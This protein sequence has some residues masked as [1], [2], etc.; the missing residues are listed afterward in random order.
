MSR[1]HAK[2]KYWFRFSS[3][4]QPIPISTE[5]WYL[6]LACILNMGL[7]F[8][9][10]WICQPLI[11]IAIVIHLILGLTCWSKTRPPQ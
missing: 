4:G 7:C 1:K 10:A 5:G 3:F 2:E 8:L 6:L 11:V 9:F